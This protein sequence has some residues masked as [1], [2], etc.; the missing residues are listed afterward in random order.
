M[1]LSDLL[2]T[3]VRTAD[4]RS[5][6]RL[7]D[8]RVIRDGPLRS[9]IQA[10]YRVD[11]LLVGRGGVAERLGFIRHRINGPWLLRAI[12]SRLEREL[13][14]V[15]AAAVA[16]WDDGHHEILLHPE[17]TDETPGPVPGGGTATC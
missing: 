10:A 15:P 11:A 5:L 13:V 14:T 7:R 9:N 4:G 17:R 16:R 6:G 1:R 3:T 2:G 8:V 12:A